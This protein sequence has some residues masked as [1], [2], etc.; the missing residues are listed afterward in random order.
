MA[1]IPL[2]RRGQPEDVAELPFYLACDAAAYVTVSTDFID[3][4]MLRQAGG[5]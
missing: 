4:G 1:E 5:T 2:G 3:G